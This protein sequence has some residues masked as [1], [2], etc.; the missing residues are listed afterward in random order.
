MAFQACNEKESLHRGSLTLAP[1]TSCDSCRC[2]LSLPFFFSFF[3][4]VHYRG[5][6]LS[7][8]TSLEASKN[9]RWHLA[10][11]ING[12][13]NASDPKNTLQPGGENEKEDELW[14]AVAKF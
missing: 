14:K 3:F 9:D 4:S 1:Q 5:A 13:G 2:S 6:C 8:K 12:N 11:V 10:L 7:L